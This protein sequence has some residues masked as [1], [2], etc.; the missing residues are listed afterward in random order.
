MY[1]NLRVAVAQAERPNWDAVADCIATYTRVS[2]ERVRVLLE[3]FIQLGPVLALPR[4]VAT[5]NFES[6]LLA[7]L[8]TDLGVT[9]LWPTFES[10]LYA[11]QNPEKRGLLHMHVVTGY[12][13]SGGAKLRRHQ[14]TPVGERIQGQPLGAVVVMAPTGQSQRLVDYHAEWRNRVGVPGHIL[15]LESLLAPLATGDDRFRK[16]WYYPVF[17]ALASAG[18]VFLEDFDVKYAMLMHGVVRRALTEVGRFGLTPQFVHLPDI[19]A[20]QWYPESSEIAL[21]KEAEQLKLQLLST[22]V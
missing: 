15:A 6:V 5:A 8:A 9:A 2:P 3:P 14:I 20:T 4:H 16:E 13:R 11:D 22:T 21:P 12:G 10:D 18:I 19:Q 7:Q 1:M 17:F